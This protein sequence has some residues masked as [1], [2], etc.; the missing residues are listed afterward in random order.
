MGAVSSGKPLGGVGN[1]GFAR[2]N[3]AEGDTAVKWFDEGIN[4][5]TDTGGTP[6]GNMT[7]TAGGAGGTGFDK[8]AHANITSPVVHSQ[9]NQANNG[10]TNSLQS[11][12]G[13]LSALGGQNGIANQSAALGQGQNAYNRLEGI[14]GAGIQ[15]YASNANA[16]LGQNIGQLYG[17][18]A[19]GVAMNQQGALNNRIGSIDGAGM[20]GAAANQQQGMNQG[21][22]GV[23]AAGLLGSAA[24]SQGQLNQQLGGAGGVQ[25]Q[26]GALQ[27]LQNV[28]GQQQGLANQ[29][30]GL[31]N[32]TGPN[33]AQAA[34]NQ[35]TGQN[36]AAQAALMAGQ[37][38]AGAN[39]GL[40][41]RQAAQQGAATQQQ[42]V[43]QS[44]TLQAQQQIA[45]M[46]AL[47]GQQQAMGATNQNMAGIGAGLV[48]QQQ[49]GASAMGSLGMGVN[50]Q[51]Q[52][53]I[54]NLGS[55]GN[56]A[57]GA[58]QTG[59]NNQFQQGSG[60][61]GQQQANIG[62]QYQMGSGITGQQ[63]AQLGMNA[64]I[65][66]NMVGNQ[67][68][69]NN[70]AIQG[71]LGNAG[72][73]MNALGNYNTNVVNSQ[74]SVNTGNT[75]L[76]NTGMQ[77]Q[78]AFIG[79]IMSG[80]GGAMQ[81]GGARGG[82]VQSFADGGVAASPNAAWQSSPPPQQPQPAP[83]MQAAPAPAPAPQA[84]A[85]YPAPNGQGPVMPQAGPGPVT[86]PAP[87]PSNSFA[88]F[89]SGQT[90]TS[91]FLGD[92]M[93]ANIQQDKT[94]DTSANTQPMSAPQMGYGTQMLYDGAKKFSEGA[95][96][97]AANYYTGGASGAMSMMSGARGGSVN[98]F[99]SGGHVQAPTTAQKATVSG[100][101]YKNDKVHGL[102]SEGEIVLPRTVTQSED[103]VS[104]SADFVAR[105]MAKRRARA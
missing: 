7:G 22:A 80:A 73:Q 103:P 98:D 24:G 57:L 50:A 15:G 75:S 20:M 46:Q 104:A 99:R 4:K 67:M 6:L 51:Q 100:N 90:D 12:Q 42:A 48:G 19:Q 91:K 96:K 40:M 64:G 32:G 68:G 16:A 76:A 11:T 70:Q 66:Q 55:L 30:Q 94:A 23:N 77:G 92:S 85:P 83:Q 14:D 101:S 33:P 52:A 61:T 36:I 25:A 28:L 8:P 1:Q 56:Q 3:G 53:G 60:V 82:Y 59:I 102:L 5:I 78:H 81:M 26:T 105:I 18:N 72:Q 10:V 27:G 34:L 13:L 29:Y 39:V 43:G 84:A 79:G 44:A 93:K 31:A 49:G 89:L 54:A 88:Q 74:N 47:A 87:S 69:V 41:A 38:G 37:R 62:Q 86:A 45:G 63:Q 95:A 71:N 9:V 35:S 17:T 2:G 21:L 65:T 58:Q 97:M